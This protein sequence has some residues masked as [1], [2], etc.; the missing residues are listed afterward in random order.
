MGIQ[1]MFH[2]CTVFGVIEPGGSLPPE[3]TKPS[4]VLKLCW[5]SSQGKVFL[6]A[7]GLMCCLVFSV[8][9]YLSEMDAARQT[10]SSPPDLH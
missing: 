6:R 5:L 3:N 9:V 8:F 10:A 2:V 4:L 7:L 1:K